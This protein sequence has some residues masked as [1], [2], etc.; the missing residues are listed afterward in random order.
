VS[1]LRDGTVVLNQGCSYFF[2]VSGVKLFL[3]FRV[4]GILIWHFPPR[5]YKIKTFEW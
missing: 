3:I 4:G 2:V 5:K 1:L